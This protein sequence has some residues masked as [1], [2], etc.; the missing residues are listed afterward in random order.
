MNQTQG[1]Y[2]LVVAASIAKWSKRSPD[3]LTA[4]DGRLYLERRPSISPRWHA[5][6]CFQNHLIQKSTG[7]TDRPDAQQVAERWFLNL[8]QRVERGIPATGHTFGSTA[9]AFISHHQETLLPIGGSNERKIRNYKNSWNVI[10]DFLSDKLVSDVD[11]DTL[12]EL[13]KWRRNTRRVSDKTLRADV[14]FARLVLKY[15]Q[16]KRW[17]DHLPL[18]PQLGG[19]PTSPDWFSPKEWQHL[20]HVSRERI[21]EAEQSDNNARRHIIRER[22]EL[23]AFVLLMG[24]G[25]IR[26]DECLNLRWSDLT[27]ES[28]NAKLPFRKRTVLIRVRK[29]KTGERKGIG[30][31]GVLRAMEMLRSIHPDA[32]PEDKLFK[33]PHRHGI[34]QLLIAAKLRV[35]S[36]GKFRNAKT[37]R[38]TS[39]MF[40]F[41][42]EPSIR[43]H[44]LAILGG[45]SAKILEEYYLRHLTAELV[46]DRLTQAALAAS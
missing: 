45:T 8:R 42:Y 7:T 21:R 9:E 23:H 36:R 27:P 28:R 25:C 46:Q 32:Q 40:R 15:A 20:L 44:E 10:R 30:T 2:H 24:H 39:L 38:H 35:D 18:F 3:R 1:V 12:E 34:K 22:T 26:V 16:R 43:P 37:I 31:F 11:V 19:K 4:F 41:L 5:R 29:G 17:I 14:G 6:A 33:T 13:C